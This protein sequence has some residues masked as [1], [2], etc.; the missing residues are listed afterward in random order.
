MSFGVIIYSLR[1][2]MLV[3][4]SEFFEEGQWGLNLGRCATG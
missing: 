1:L 2:E 4:G 3:R